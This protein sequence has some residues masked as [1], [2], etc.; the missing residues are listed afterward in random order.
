MRRSDRGARSRCSPSFREWSLVLGTCVVI[1][2]FGYLLS[3]FDVVVVFGVLR[4]RGN[5]RTDPSAKHLVNFQLSVSFGEQ[6]DVSRIIFQQSN[7]YTV[8]NK[9]PLL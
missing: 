2:W 4:Y 7:G 9:S 1:V 5:G 8:L 3:L 6:I